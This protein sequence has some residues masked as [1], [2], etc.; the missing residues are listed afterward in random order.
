MQHPSHPLTRLA[1]LA[2]LLLLSALTSPRIQAEA[3]TAANLAFDTY[4]RAVEGR[5]DR[6]HSDPATFLTTGALPY[7]QT[8]KILLEDLAEPGTAHA[9]DETNLGAAIHHWRG[10]AFVPGATATAFELLL[11]NLDAYPQNFAPQVLHAAVLTT[12]GDHLQTLIRVREH[13]GLTVVMDTAYNTDFGR[14]DATHG[15]CTSH[16]TRIAEIASPNSPAEHPLSPADE[17][18]FLYRL[19]TYWSWEQRDGG[20]F[21]QIETVSLSRAI[22]TGL[23]WLLRPYVQSIPR[24]SLGFTLT[25]ARK[26]LLTRSQAARQSHPAP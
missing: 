19:D 16:S 15:F 4:S 21:L 9:P 18:G 8:G 5:L 2:S 17:H 25:A 6:Q 10:T 26:A 22:P 1:Q 20:L 3:P 13:H 23:G 12:H 11:R 7:L 14:L 24:D